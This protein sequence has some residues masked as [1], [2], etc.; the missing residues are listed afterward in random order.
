MTSDRVYSAAIT[1][2][3]AAEEVR[4]SAGTHL[5]P[6]VAATLLEVLEPAA[7]PLSEAA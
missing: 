7:A 3:A 5:D 1:P 2:Q 4:R 6:L